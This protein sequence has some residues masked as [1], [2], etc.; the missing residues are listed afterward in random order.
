M[1]NELDDFKEAAKVQ[2][3]VQDEGQSPDGLD[4][5]GASVMVRVSIT[6]MLLSHKLQKFAGQSSKRLLEFD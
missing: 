5:M 2:S 1:G 3:R 6:R 4:K